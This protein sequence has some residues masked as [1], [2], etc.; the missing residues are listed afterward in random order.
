MIGWVLVGAR[1]VTL[2]DHFVAAFWLGTFLARRFRV[3]EFRLVEAHAPDLSSVAQGHDLTH[4][5]ESDLL[6]CRSP[7]IQ[8]GRRED[9][10]DRIR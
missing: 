3:A 10:R 4:D 2:R 6:R 9:P 1:R 8:A 7:Q 5:A